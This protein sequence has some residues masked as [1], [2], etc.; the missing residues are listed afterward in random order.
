MVP[1]VRERGRHS[2]RLFS[3]KHYYHAARAAA[4][5][6]LCLL[7][8][9]IWQ[10]AGL[11]LRG[12]EGAKNRR[13]DREASRVDLPFNSNDQLHIMPNTTTEYAQLASGPGLAEYFRKCNEQPVKKVKVCGISSKATVYLMGN[14]QGYHSGARGYTMEVGTCDPDGHPGDC[15]EVDF[16]E[17]WGSAAQTWTITRCVCHPKWELEGPLLT[18]KFKRGP[19]CPP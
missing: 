15:H 5:A 16:L 2:R 10:A 19:G 14:C 4:G 8:L 9:Q 6:G 12:E 1:R 7:L 17:E 18:P 13:V 11:A 3:M